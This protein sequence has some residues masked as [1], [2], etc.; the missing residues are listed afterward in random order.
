MR[1]WWNHHYHFHIRLACPP[2][3]AGCENQKPVTGDDGCDGKELANWFAMLKKSAIWAAQQAAANPNPNP[4]HKAPPP[5]KKQIK[6]YDLPKDCRSVLTAGGF[7]PPTAE[8]ELPPEA[9]AALET[10]E[11][12][13]PIPLLT[14][15][16]L[17]ILLNGGKL[18]MPMPDRNPVR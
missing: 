8:D 12:G 17:D 6:L 15:A 3:M 14:Q 16:Q 2:G 18:G 5:K 7:E 13:Q 10:K 1:P 4:D 9:V 11:A